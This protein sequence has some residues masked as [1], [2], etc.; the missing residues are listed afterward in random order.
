MVLLDVL[1]RLIRTSDIH[2]ALED[3]ISLEL[4]FFISKFSTLEIFS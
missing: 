2:F 4:G 1:G 3:V